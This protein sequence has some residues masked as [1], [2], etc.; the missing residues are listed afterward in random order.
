MLDMAV[1]FANTC[2]RGSFFQNTIRRKSMNNQIELSDE[3]LEA[4]IGGSSGTQTNTA[5]QFLLPI[6]VSP[7]NNV[8]VGTLTGNG[9]SQSGAFNLIVADNFAAQSNA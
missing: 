1:Y 8:A 2:M 7:T 4:V 6:I 9:N 5:S 3:Q